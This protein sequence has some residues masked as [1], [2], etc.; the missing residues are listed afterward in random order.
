MRRSALLLIALGVTL[1]EPARAQTSLVQT[2][3]DVTNVEIRLVRTRA[4]GAFRIDATVNNPNDFTV[5][6]VRVNCTMMDRR[7]RVLHS[8]QSTILDTFPANRR[9]V[10]RKLDIGAWPPDAASASCRSISAKKM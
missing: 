2:S 3:V 5:K 9:S 1:A 10:V 8:Y 7:G 6:D 4:R